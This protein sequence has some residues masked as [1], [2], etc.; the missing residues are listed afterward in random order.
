[1]A[2][3]PAACPVCGERLAIKGLS[4]FMA[5]VVVDKHTKASPGCLLRLDFFP[6]EKRF[7]LRRAVDPHEDV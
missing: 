6:E 2:D 1:M 4:F 3:E 7:E 5:S